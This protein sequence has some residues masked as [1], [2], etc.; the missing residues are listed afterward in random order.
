ML[1]NISQKWQYFLI[2]T[3]II[4]L[5]GCPVTEQ[6]TVDSPSPNQLQTM[7]NEGNALSIA[8]TLGTEEATIQV[9]DCG[10]V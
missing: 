4:F 2:L 1:F 5:S 8:S 9:T 3:M 6:A 7:I 10:I